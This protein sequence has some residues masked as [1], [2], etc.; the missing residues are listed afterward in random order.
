MSDDRSLTDFPSEQNIFTRFAPSDIS[1]SNS[2]LGKIPNFLGNAAI[3][4]SDNRI[5]PISKNPQ[6]LISF[7][8]V[9]HQPDFGVNPTQNYLSGQNPPLFIPVEHQPDFGDS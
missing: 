1:L 5:T 3:Y 9:D 6:Q 8:P 2:S 7:V 4:P